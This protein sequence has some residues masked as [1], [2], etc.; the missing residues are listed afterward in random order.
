MYARRARSIFCTFECSDSSVLLPTSPGPIEAWQRAVSAT[1][2]GRSILSEVW[3]ENCTQVWEWAKFGQC[4][5]HG[6]GKIV[7]HTCS[8]FSKPVHNTV[9]M[10]TCRAVIFCTFECSY[11]LVLCHILLKLHTLTRLIESFLTVY[12]LFSCIEVKLSILLGAH[13]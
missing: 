11:S 8:Y 13:A 2:E 10:Y 3:L 7:L 5:T 1:S 6:W 12:G 4:A 9:T